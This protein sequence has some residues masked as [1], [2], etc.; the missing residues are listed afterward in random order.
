MSV[1]FVVTFYKVE[2]RQREREECIKRNILFVNKTCNK[3][4][5]ILKVTSNDIPCPETIAEKFTAYQNFVE[6]K[7]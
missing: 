6:T 4:R 7:Y 5:N 2:R 1:T 3:K